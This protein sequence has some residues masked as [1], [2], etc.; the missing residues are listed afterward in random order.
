MKSRFLLG[1]KTFRFFVVA[2]FIGLICLI[3]Q[4]TTFLVAETTFEPYV[5]YNIFQKIDPVNRLIDNYS[6]LFLPGQYSEINGGWDFGGKLGIGL[7]DK[8]LLFVA[9]GS[10][11]T[12]SSGMIYINKSG[13]AL[14]QGTLNLLIG[15]PDNFK[16]RFLNGQAGLELVPYQ[17]QKVSVGVSVTGGPALTKFIV[18]GTGIFYCNMSQSTFTYTYSIPYEN[19]S[20][21]FETALTIE[22]KP[23]LTSEEN[24]TLT[25]TEAFP[26]R[27][28]TL[29]FTIGSKFADVG[30]VECTRN[31][32]FTG[33][34]RIDI[35]K[36]DTLKKTYINSGDDL[37]LDLSSLFINLG[38]KIR[39]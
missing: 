14:S 4:A 19:Q 34:G 15:Y 36:G 33:D 20:T 16:I 5:G 10:Y 39:W 37:K 9:K 23:W 22:F 38:I 7:I 2:Q 6:E 18:E 21:V 3:N 28:T 8:K 26:I 11:L 27:S 24:V 1:K 31:I 12:A 25:Q 35:K 32:D 30:T 29:Q 13:T 17:K